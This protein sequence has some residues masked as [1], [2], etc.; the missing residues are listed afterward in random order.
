MHQ[1]RILPGVGL[2]LA[3]CALAPLL[4]VHA[5]LASDAIPVGQITFARFAVQGALMLPVVLLMRLGWGMSPRQMGMVALRALFLLLAT[6]GFVAAIAVMPIADALAIAFVEPFIVLLLGW[7]VF[8]EKVGPRRIAASAVGFAGALLVIQPSFVAFGAAAFYPLGTA[9]AFACY[10]LITRHMSLYFHPVTMQMQTSVAGVL[11][12]LPVL[13]WAEGTGIAALDPVMPQGI[14]WLWLFG[15][16]FWATL[17]HMAIT[18]ALQLAPSSTLVPLHYLEMV[19]A[20]TFGYL[21]FG[22]F[23]NLL[24]WAGIA[25]IVASGLYIIHRERLAARHPPLAVP[26]APPPAGPAA[27]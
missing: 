23:P 19:S 18:Y 17:A 14:Y 2:M 13:V 1:H 26:P 8:G 16:G 24:T 4:D 10:M 12:C 3:F 20:V 6:Y 21:V 25:T 7:L 15:V 22:D 5:K 27:G 9:V 11:L